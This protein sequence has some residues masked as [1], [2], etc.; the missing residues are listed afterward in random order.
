MSIAVR[1]VPA[2]VA[3]AGGLAI[4]APAARAGET[5]LFNCFF[6]PQHFMCTEMVPELGNRI[7]KA[8]EGRVKLRIPPKSVAAP[9]DQYDAVVNGVVDG[10]LQFNTFIAN[11]VSGVQ[12]AHLP[13]VGSE[14]SEPASV[15]LWRT[16][17]KFFADK[18]E[19]K[20]VVLLSLFAS[21]GGE[22]ASTI[23]KP[24]RTVE[25]IAGRKM[26]ALPGTTANVIKATGSPVVS[27]P[28]VQM[29]EIISKGV[30]DGYTGVPTSS[31]EQFKLTPYTKS[32]TEFSRKIFQPS[33]SFFVS[34]KKWAKIDKKDQ[35]AILAAT[36]GDYA[37]WIGA[38]QDVKHKANVKQVFAAGVKRIEG[39]DAELE[40]LVKLGQ[41]IVDDWIKKVGDMKVDGKAVI[42]FYRK[43]IVEERAR[44]KS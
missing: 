23:D 17:Q 26:W 36:G 33:F 43:A 5:I 14:D 28:A 29:L 18:G 10:A 27:G 30:V 42:E 37:R 34:S 19:Y 8:T 12:V 20:D 7:D 35:D 22:F 25:D 11:R 39:A 15:A 2:V 16:Y 31:T 13:F 21:N 6:P 1:P 9:P 44:V 3:L 4:S 24:I 38:L 32:I 40:K 41:P